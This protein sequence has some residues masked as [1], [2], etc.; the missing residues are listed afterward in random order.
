MKFLQ[1]VSISLFLGLL[2]SCSQKIA[3]V[4]NIM[5]TQYFWTPELRNDEQKNDYRITIS[6]DKFNISGIWV[7]RQI[8]NS[9]RGI[10][11]NEFG[12]NMFEFICTARKCEL[13]NVF[14][15]ANKWYIRKTIAEDIQFILEIDNPSFEKGRIAQRNFDNDTLVITH[16]NK[17]LYRFPD[18]EMVMKNKKRNLTYS[19]RLLSK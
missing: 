11:M 1:F 8:D 19:F 14:A 18:D 5:P 16:K 9:W 3:P 12:L 17:V 6:T 2:T 13:K 7:V 4:S 10:I 15:A